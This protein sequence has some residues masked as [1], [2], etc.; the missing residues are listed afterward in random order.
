MVSNQVLGARAVVGLLATFLAVSGCSHF[1]HHESAAAPTAAVNPAPLPP[2]SVSAVPEDMTAT[3]A[4]IAAG[5]IEH[6]PASAPVDTRGAVNPS[7]PMHY[8][9]KKGDT[10][11]G[12]ASMYLK[13]P[14]LWPEVWIINPQIPNPHLIY[15]GD[16]LA[17]AYGADGRPHVSVSQAGTVRLDP[18][19]RSEPLNGAIPTIAYSSI[20]AFLSKPTIVSEEQIRH[21]PY[22]LAFR[23]QHQVGGSGNEVYIRDLGAGQNSRYTIVH[24]AGPLR[25]PDD[26]KLLGYEAIYTATALIQRA[27]DP[28]KAVLIDPA[29]ETLGGDRLLASEDTQAMLNFTP[30]TPST[31][32][33]GYILDVVGGTDLVGLYQVVVINRGRSQGVDPGTVLAIDHKGEV[34]PDVYRGGRNI[35]SEAS[36]TFA[37]KVRLPSERNGTL[38]VFKSFDRASY[39]LI[40]GASDIIE[41][42]DVVRNP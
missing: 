2:G 40:V 23:D 35:G 38:L 15:P 19:L 24:I 8:T 18:R 26:H 32:T 4:A 28:A 6:A 27:G 12:I 25:D 7:A 17:L 41:V 34:V 21:A 14:W 20:A 16:E 5:D 1:E 30:H 22:V 37:P 10:L 31:S 29:R 42:G 9:V 13:D 33:H 11:W 36:R 3:Q 39:A